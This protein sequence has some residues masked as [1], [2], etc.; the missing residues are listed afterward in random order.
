MGV[1][2]DFVMCLDRCLFLHVERRQVSWKSKHLTFFVLFGFILSYQEQLKQHDYFSNLL[3]TDFSRLID[4]FKH[5]FLHS[6][7]NSF[8]LVDNLIRR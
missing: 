3:G 5:L 1:S 2:I 4:R 7:E 8:S 6:T